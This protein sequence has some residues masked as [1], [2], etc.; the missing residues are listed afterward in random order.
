M[1]PLREDDGDNQQH[2]IQDVNEFQ[3]QA[4]ASDRYLQS[5]F[6]EI[7]HGVVQDAHRLFIDDVAAPPREEHAAKRHQKRRQLKCRYQ[8]ALQHAEQRSENDRQQNRPAG[9]H[10]AV[11]HFRDQ[12][13]RE[14]DDGTDRQVDATG[15]DH[16]HRPDGRDA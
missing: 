11:D 6:D 5:V 16:D 7:E 8:N 15:K 14:G 9:V 12:H 2:K 4:T 13:A 3:R 10:A 1:R